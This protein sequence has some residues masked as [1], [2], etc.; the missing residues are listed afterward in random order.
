MCQQRLETK[1]SGYH[2]AP[3][4]PTQE[5]GS[6]CGKNVSTPV[7]STEGSGSDM[8]HVPPEG[9]IA[10]VDTEQVMGGFCQRVMHETPNEN[11]NNIGSLPTRV[12]LNYLINDNE[13]VQPSISHPADKN[14]ETELGKPASPLL[15]DSYVL[16]AENST[17]ITSVSDGSMTTEELGKGQNEMVNMSP[18]YLPHPPIKHEEEL[19]LPE[20]EEFVESEGF[21]PPLDE[22]SSL[23]HLLTTAPIVSSIQSDC[24][25]KDADINLHK[26]ETF[27]YVPLEAQQNKLEVCA[28]FDNLISFNSTCMNGLPQTSDMN[29]AA[30]CSLGTKPLAD[31]QKKE[32]SI[33]ENCFQKGRQVEPG[34]VSLPLAS[35]SSSEF[36]QVEPKAS[37]LDDKCC[38]PGYVLL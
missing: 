26:N 13:I 24:S 9:Y 27:D 12:N 36:V 16:A 23:S 19:P 33:H 10:C 6:E 17:S 5:H 21:C 18:G 8:E 4:S 3:V 14:I 34:Y 15:T 22:Q 7:T 1:E 25:S 38:A 30:C 37:K 2:S 28:S 35:Q 20:E 11:N 31:V 32:G 29:D